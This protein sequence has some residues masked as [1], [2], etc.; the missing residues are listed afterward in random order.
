MGYLKKYSAELLV[1][2]GLIV[3]FFASRFY[4][5]LSLPMFTDEAIY[6]RWSQ[7]ARQDAAQR[8]ISLTDGK[9]PLFIWLTAALLGHVQDPLLAGRL[10]SVVAG[11][12]TMVGLFCLS[13]L[14]FKNRWIGLLTSLVYLVYPFGLVYDRMALYDSLVGT[15]TVWGLFFVILLVRYLRLDL[16]MILGV[17]AGIGTLNKTNSFFTI[18]LLPF[19][20]LLLDWKK[21]KFWERVTKWFGLAIVSV[22]F[23]YAIYSVLRL[24]PWFYII[25][26]K[27]ATFVYP[28]KEW[29]L[30]PFTFLWGNLWIG[31]RDWLVRYFGYPFIILTLASFFI[32]KKFLREKLLLIMWFAAPFVALA[33]FGRTIYPRYILFMTLSLLPLVAYSFYHLLF[34]FNK[35]LIGIVLIYLFL[36]LPVYSDYLILTNFSHSQIPQSDKDQYFNDWPSGDGVNE[37]IVYFKQQAKDRKIAIYTE[38]TFG[39]MPKVYEIYLLQNPNFYIEG[40]WPITKFLPKELA[41]SAKKMPTYVVFYQPCP[42]CPQKGIAP[43]TWPLKQVYQKKKVTDQTYLTVYQVL[44]E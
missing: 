42:D 33:L 23:T 43:T 30:H 41:I 10:V 38:G 37:S 3:G 31:E 8:F 7:I 21:K 17:V 19:S 4:H 2:V 20:L 35:K 29:I 27:D 12:G 18:Y 36:M 1:V 14:L 16:A 15:F 13:T 6:I 11:F 22:V 32:N 40:L 9:Q 24:S 28:L 5:I 25:G 26:Q 39:L 34:A 44:P